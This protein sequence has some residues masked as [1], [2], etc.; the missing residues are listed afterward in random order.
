MSMMA[1]G[2]KPWPSPF[3]QAPE[4]ALGGVAGDGE[5]GGLDV[6]EV[7]FDMPCWRRP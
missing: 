2:W 5:V 1:L 6:A 7:F 3:L 4:D